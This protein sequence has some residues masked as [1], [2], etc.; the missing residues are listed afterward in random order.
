MECQSCEY[1]YKIN[2]I[3]DFIRSQTLKQNMKFLNSE[4]EP[5][6]TPI[7]RKELL[8]ILGINYDSCR[9]PLG[10]VNDA[11]NLL[12]SESGRNRLYDVLNEFIS[13][14][15]ECEEIT[16]S[17]SWL[18]YYSDYK[19]RI[20]YLDNRK[21]T[22]L[23]YYLNLLMNKVFKIRVFMSS[24]DFSSKY[25]MKDSCKPVNYKYWKFGETIYDITTKKPVIERDVIHNDYDFPHCK[26]LRVKP[27]Q[28]VVNFFKKRFFKNNEE[29]YFKFKE[30][31]SKAFAGRIATNTIV[32]IIGSKENITDFESS[33]ELPD[34]LSFHFNL[35]CLKR[36]IHI[37]TENKRK[38]C[39]L[40]CRN[41]T[42]EELKSNIYFLFTFPGTLFVLTQQ[43]IKQENDWFKTIE[44]RIDGERGEY[45]SD[46]APYDVV[47]FV[48]DSYEI[49]C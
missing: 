25:M 16:K 7:R 41:P 42:I 46:T 28:D 13:M 8:D 19:N 20:Y 49:E 27:R 43:P 10:I 5:S 18:F 40:V 2:N 1:F 4:L 21:P 23:G 47:N 30:V 39:L 11:R 36:E 31:L 9:I 37:Q 29:S 34:M 44:I 32:N 26:M 22:E 3:D 17:I 38:A 45:L 6:K 35:C 15:W 24:H 12:R 33:I 48:F 14:D